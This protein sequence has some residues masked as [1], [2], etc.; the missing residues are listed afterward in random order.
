VRA[1]LRGAY[2][3][4]ATAQPGN[5][6]NV[7]A[8]SAFRYGQVVGAGRLDELAASNA[9]EEAADRCGLPRREAVMTI[10][11]GLRRGARHPLEVGK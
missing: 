11:A 7:L 2:D 1:L 6:N 3:D 5:R 10:R 9:L 4:T 8:R